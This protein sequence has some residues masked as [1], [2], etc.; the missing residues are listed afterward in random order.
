MVMQEYVLVGKSF[1]YETE[2]VEVTSI[3]I[4]ECTTIMEIAIKHVP[5]LLEASLVLAHLVIF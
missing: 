2:L 5:I 4:N 3:D 1:V